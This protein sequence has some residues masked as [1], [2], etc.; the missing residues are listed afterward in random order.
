MTA[1]PT[2]KD[3]RIHSPEE[4]RA[5]I[6]DMKEA[7]AVFYSMAQRVGNHA[8]IEHTGLM[9]EYIKLCDAAVAAGIDFTCANTHLG[10]ELPFGK[11][12]LVYIVE[13]LDC[14]Y[15]PTIAGHLK[16]Q[17]APDIEQIVAE[18]VRRGVKAALEGDAVVELAAQY[19]VAAEGM[20]HNDP[21][22]YDDYEPAIQARYRDLGRQMLQD[23]G[24]DFKE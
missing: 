4:L 12:N 6:A 1:T 10:Q 15:G 19:I 23:L 7:S 5:M 11:H 14:I 21:P 8:F 22:L 16:A 13:K 9:N 3:Q 20:G 2:P 17:L 24:R 18:R